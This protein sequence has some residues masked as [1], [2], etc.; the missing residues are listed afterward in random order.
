MSGII[1]VPDAWRTLSERIVAEGGV[2]LLLGR[3]DSG[4]TTLARWL[5]STLT[6][7][8]R[9]VALLDGD[10]GQS[11]LGPPATAGL[12]F[13]TAS[14]ADQ[15]L[16]PV[17]LRFVGAVSPPGHMLP[18]AVALKRLAEKA[19]AM[20]AEVLLVDTTG[21][22]LGPLG[23]RL[24]F[25]KIELLAP[26]H[27]I[28]LQ[29]EGELEPILRLFEG[30]KGMAVSRLPL[31]PQ[32]TPRT[33]Q[34]RRLYRA[35]RFFD[36]FQAAFPL[37]LS[38]HEV[39]VLG[40]WV[41]AGEALDHAELRALSMELRTSVLGGERGDD[42]AFLL[43]QGEPAADGLPLAKSRLGVSVLQIT[44]LDAIRGLL[45]GLTD[46]E[47]ELLA[48]GLLQHLDPATGRL[49]C[50]TPFGD[51]AAI[52]NVHCGSLRLDPSGQEVADAIAQP[53]IP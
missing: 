10:I 22:V 36:H 42:E 23:R 7:A 5:L 25:H 13:A 39:A 50:L 53:V 47:N 28:A 2:A 9:R 6:A 19:S 17:S 31:S 27:L 49:V 33:S 46:Q 44:A 37:E 30:R 40:S 43:V 38:L 16:H 52:R 4:K 34:G 1:E 35:Q 14:P 48:L 29:R 3:S 41:Q 51:R 11:T 20:G 32:I 15:P 45:L 12:A 8:G 18:L 21:L 26:H 24:K